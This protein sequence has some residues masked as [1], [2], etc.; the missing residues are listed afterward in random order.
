MCLLRATV[1][2]E[3]V[4]NIQPESGLLNSETESHAFSY[5]AHPLTAVKMESSLYVESPS[6]RL[7][8]LRKTSKGAHYLTKWS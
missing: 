2:R 3:G 8:P 4:S 1:Q 7:L 6:G 5:S